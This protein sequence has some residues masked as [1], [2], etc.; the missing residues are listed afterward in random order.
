MALHSYICIQYQLIIGNTGVQGSMFEYLIVLIQIYL[1]SLLCH[2]F[3]A[4]QSDRPCIWRR[5]VGLK[6]IKSSKFDSLTTIDNFHRI[7]HLEY[8]LSKFG[9]VITNLDWLSILVQKFRILS[10]LKLF[11]T[12]QIQP[13]IR[14]VQITPNFIQSENWS[15]WSKIRRRIVSITFDLYHGHWSRNNL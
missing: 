15:K 11:K 7:S 12:V 5:V 3:V 14:R 10:K 1:R 2:T 4:F 6:L 13:E 9:L 8:F